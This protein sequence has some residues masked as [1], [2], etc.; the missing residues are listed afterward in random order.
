MHPSY[1]NDPSLGKEVHAYLVKQGLETPMTDQVKQSAEKKIAAITDSFSDIMIELGL[2]TTDDSL[3]DTPKR[4]AKMY[5]NE[6]FYG[7]NYDYFPK[8]TAIENK[9]KTNGSFLLEKNI[10]VQSNCEHHFVVIDGLATVAYI[11]DKKLLGL[12]KL[13]RIVQFFA[14]R[15]QVQERLTE[16]IRA[17]IQ[18]VAQTEDV[19]VYV[20]AKHW[21]VKSRGIQDQTSS[22]V[23][24]SVGGV[25]AD[26]VSEIRK[27]FLNLARS[28]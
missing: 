17:T 16:Q 25:F 4:V 2:D 6:I 19:A 22:T 10:N 20:D 26:K 9:M 24:L 15:P 18:Y 11:A 21:C 3:M 14:K 5:V 1:K 8:C 13:N 27:E 28:G 7:L 12:S 23:T